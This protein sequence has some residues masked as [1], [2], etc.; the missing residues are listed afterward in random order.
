MW[1]RKQ[2]SWTTFALEG[3]A[4]SKA[5]PYQKG[6]LG[7]SATKA[8]GAFIFILFSFTSLYS[9]LEYPGPYLDCRRGLARVRNPDFLACRASDKVFSAAEREREDA[10]VPKRALRGT[11]GEPL[12]TPSSSFPHTV[13]ACCL[14]DGESRCAS[15]PDPVSDNRALERGES[16]PEESLKQEILLESGSTSAPSSARR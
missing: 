14:S 6:F 4:P 15:F 2:C 8:R 3:A 9:I 16:V 13:L 11:A 10:R 5:S 12:I 7:D 1:K